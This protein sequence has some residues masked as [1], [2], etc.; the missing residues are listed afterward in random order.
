MNTP[1]SSTDAD[2]GKRFT[3]L[4]HLFQSDLASLQ[5][6]VSKLRKALLDLEA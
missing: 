1:S 2:L 3:N 5:N 6:V 4:D